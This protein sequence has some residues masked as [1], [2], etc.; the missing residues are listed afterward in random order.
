M[1][2]TQALAC[3]LH[4]IGF[5]TQPSTASDATVV[6]TPFPDAERRNIATKANCIQSLHWVEETLRYTYAVNVTDIIWQT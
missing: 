1:A 3:I 2:A 6:G 5:L 4:E